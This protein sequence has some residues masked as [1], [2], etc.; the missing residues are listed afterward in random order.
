MINEYVVDCNGR[1]EFEAGTFTL[2]IVNICAVTGSENPDTFR[3]DGGLL[4][5]GHLASRNTTEF[6]V[7]LERDNLLAVRMSF[8]P[9]NPHDNRRYTATQFVALRNSPD[10]DGVPRRQTDEG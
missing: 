1:I 3:L 8:S 7:W 9:T 4:L 5:N 2:T 6:D 10:T